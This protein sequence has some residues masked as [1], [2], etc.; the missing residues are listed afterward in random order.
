MDALLRA[1]ASYDDPQGSGK[2]ADAVAANAVRTAPTS[3]TAPVF[4]ADSVAFSLA[5][6]AAAG[7]AVGSPVTASDEDPDDMVGY[8]LSGAGAGQFAIDS[9]GQIT[10]AP[11]TMLDHETT[12]SYTLT[13]TATDASNASDT[14]TVTISVTNVDEAGTVTFSSSRP[15]VGASLT[16]TLSDPD[17][18]PSSVSWVWERSS[19]SGNNW[20]D[21]AGATSES[22]TPVAADAG[23]LL[24][25]TASYTDPEGSGKS[26][27]VVSVVPVSNT[28]PVFASG[29]Y[30]LSVAENA[31]AGT[32]VGSPVGATDAGDDTV[33]FSLSGAGAT[34]FDI[35]GGGQ[36]TVR[37]SGSLD[38]E[39]RASYSLTVAAIDTS[40]AF[41]TAAVIINVT[42]VDEAGTVTFSSSRP[43]VGTALTASLS[44]PDGAT[45]SVTWVW[46]GSSNNGSSWTD[47]SGANSAGYTPVSADVGALLRATASYTDPEGA[48]K[49]AR[50]AQTA[51]V[52]TPGAVFVSD[53]LTFS[54]DENAAAGTAVGSPV[55]ASDTVVYRLKGAG[56]NLFAI[57]SGGQI[58][59]RRSGSL[60]YETTR[61]YT[62]T[63]T[64]SGR[65]GESD[66]AT[67][68][69]KVANVDE[70]GTVTFSS[71]RPQVG[72]ALTA[73]LSDPDGATSS[74]TWR[75]AKSSNNGRSWTDIAG[76][77]SDSYT[78]VTADTGA[79]LRVT[80]SYTDPQGSDKSSIGLQSAPVSNPA[81]VFALSYL[82]FT[83]NENEAAGAAVGSPVT[84]TD[85]GDD[86]VSYSLDGTGAAS[87]DI[88]G[89][90]QITV[91]SGATL[92]FETTRSYRLTVTATD[93]LNAT[94]TATVN[95]DVRNVDEPGTVAFSSSQPV[96]GT[97]LT[98]EL[99][100]PDGR[101]YSVRWVWAASTD[102]GGIWTGI[103]GA[104]SPR[105]TPV[106]AD[107]GALLRATASY[108]D[109]QGSGKSAETAQ[110]ATVSN[111]APV[112]VSDTL[113]F[114][115]D[116]N[117]V[118]GARV[119]AP[120]GA[121]DAGDDTITYSLGGADAGS[122]AIDS[123]GQITLGAGVTPDYET[124]ASY[125]LTVT[126]T[127]TLDAT[128]TA[129]V[130]INV[131]NV[132]E[133]GTVAFSSSQPQVGTA[134]TATLSD[135]DGPTGSVGWVWATSSNN[136]RTWTDINGVTSPGYTP[137]A[138]DAGALLR[139]TAFYTDP[140]GSGKSADA[141]QT[142]TVSNPAPVFASDSF[143]LSVDENVP[144]GTTV[145][146]PVT[147]TD[148]GDDMVA[149]RLSGAGAALFDID[150]DGH[151]TVRNS[152]SLDY[153]AERSYVLTVTATDTS[154]AIGTATV[155]IDV[156]NVD[157]AGTV[158]LSS[159]LPQVGTGLTATLSDPDGAAGLVSWR[160]ARSSDNGNSWTDI[161]G[162]NSAGY[163]PVTPDVGDLLAATASYTDPQGSNKSA[164]AVSAA[165]VSNPAPVFSSDSF[166]LSVDENAAAGT[167]V[168]SSV[169]ATDAGD[170]VAYRLSGAGAALFDID[171]NGRITVGS[172]KALD[173][174]TTES[175][176]LAV[177]ATDTSGASDTAG[178]IIEVANV[179]EAGTVTFSSLEP[180]V[181]TALTATLSDP[182]GATS[183]VR[184]VWATSPDSGGSWTDIEGA[185]S[186]RYTPV[187]ADMGVLLA[188]TASYTDPQGADK[189]S[190]AVSAAL[191]SN[192][193]PIFVSDSWVLTVAED[194]AAGAVV[195]APVRATDV[196]EGAVA[197]SLSGAGA[198]L[199]D[200]DGNGRITVGSGTALDFETT[201]SYR[202]TVTATDSLG[203]TG[204]ATV[205]IDVANV[206]E[207]ATVTL[208]SGKPQV[209]HGLTATVSDP[210]GTIRSVSWVWARS[211]NNGRTWAGI[212]GAVSDT[213]TPVT[214]DVGV[215]L[216]A[217]ATYTDPQGSNKSA[218]AVSTV[219]VS[220]PA[221][222]F[223]SDSLM[224][225]LAENAVGGTEVG[226][227]VT[228]TDTGD[229]TVSY[230]LST[231]AG[232]LF[233][234]DRNGQIT[235]R[236]GRTL[237]YETMTSVTLTV[238]A[239]DRSNM[240]DTATVTI[241]V[242]NVDEAGTVTLS[243][244]EPVIGVAV[245]ATLTDPDGATSLVNWVWA[246]SS[247]NGAGWTDI[248]GT[249]SGSYTPVTADVGALLR[250]TASYTDPYDSGK[251]AGGVSAAPVSNTPPMFASGSIE[252]SVPENSAGGTR[253]GAPLGAIDA[254]GGTVAYRLSGAGAALFDIDG[255]GQI[256]VRSSGSL[257]YETT[258]SY[259]L[260]VAATDTLNA[261]GTATV[262]IDVD[263]V[264]EAGTAALSSSQP[265]V[266]T[267]L[268]ATVSDPDG[269][270]RSLSW[271]WARSSDSGLTWTDIRGTR[272]AVYRPGSVDVDAVLRATASYTDPQGPGKSASVVTA[273]PVQALT[274]SNTAPVF[275]ALFWGAVVAENATAGA[276]VGAP[277]RATDA[278]DTV[279]YR[280]SGA[281][282]ALFDID[283][284][285][286]VTVRSSGSL[287][288]ETTPSFTLTVTATDTSGLTGTATLIIDVNNVDEAGTVTLSP[289][290]PQVGTGLTATLSDPDGATGSV[291]WRW[292][293]SS[294]N[295]AGWTDISGAASAGYTPVAAD[296]GALL[297][298]TAS[299]TDPQGS[300][301]SAGGLGRAGVEPCSGVLSGLLHAR[302]G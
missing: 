217:T 7:T 83:V 47:I 214:A 245:T 115:V 17:G 219:Q 46:A 258:G 53:S 157:E 196:G 128:A 133:P 211:S 110:T 139:V 235:L 25:A 113:T 234:I 149:Y 12:A 194:A 159:T 197:Y 248:A 228:A 145:G 48:G 144:A 31:V 84:A 265:Q 124:T 51:L 207:A 187:A 87:F 63:V 111:P 160:W 39:T 132:D 34:L 88:D 42:N 300:D 263:N 174:E 116:E 278:G 164:N 9:G 206:D 154:G 230:R 89:N 252:W 171:G 10:V 254:G 86:T 134:L 289:M 259:T 264:E 255:D 79:L 231:N 19:D 112:F 188:A 179:D 41:D 123:A 108:S 122:F 66:T 129:T 92:D 195:G 26:A 180:R 90:G 236:S 70:A 212:P 68:T 98:A 238:T 233:D 172:G 59:V 127:D 148:A 20:T 120:V 28:A 37:S 142:A 204:T 75:W 106:T 78:P 220:K 130:N 64:A 237:D 45:S 209:G 43:Q 302:R 50:A 241:N 291:S 60:D 118:P 287:D 44:D 21:I 274:V 203:A 38:Y 229:D 8:S 24:R 202:L 95:I 74:V 93:T 200:I 192:V 201:A 82:T 114:S 215:V 16:A 186:A 262:R 57:D 147:A 11:G 109:R 85:A 35:G 272:A 276:G 141:V 176:R 283:G 191:V 182:D 175:Y 91:A 270:T 184:W 243:S 213:Y 185:R 153:E 62:L 246:R 239:T 18:A 232:A 193:P 155:N 260:L 5:E 143:T 249:N 67:V 72:T 253:V 167:T 221:P 168:G 136:G 275:V 40:N 222:V 103:I 161:S 208:S 101:I 150:G 295:G 23:A 166:T 131:T 223:V 250:V 266:G 119:G 268:T 189:S 105:Y 33:S 65:P 30:T 117:A 69:I 240:S 280:L 55:G 257:D 13:A 138:A 247:N 146:S 205:T 135:P 151:V 94:D 299:Y 152:G 125:T 36:I 282:A 126:A 190:S 288:Y 97:V 244:P 58:T 251:S 3:N 293:R 271:R 165:P 183:S 261:T 294:D 256:T 298:A 137:A 226:S 242:V 163:L 296:V 4:T 1:T 140:Q 173:F 224:F 15:Q 227:P 225:T 210:D 277:L 269:A 286:Q 218:R 49:S 96:V 54:V 22:Y 107:V 61:S 76:V 71:S 121:T 77:A 52:S 267:R 100:D 14:V 56:A 102:G 281:G 73:S 273:N 290:V 181:G 2:S 156:G 81:P 162:A 198:A 199:F 297:R 284:D 104:T 170:T 32:E 177:T 216:R 99:S 27:D 6:D 285:G 178:L 29:S 292:A 80:A 279:A 158:G 169:T 301:K